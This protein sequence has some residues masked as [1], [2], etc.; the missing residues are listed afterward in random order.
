MPQEGEFQVVSK[1]K[2]TVLSIV[3]MLFIPLASAKAIKEV[4]CSTG[5]EDIISDSIYW[6]GSIETVLSSKMQENLPFFDSAS[7][8]EKLAGKKLIDLQEGCGRIPNR[9]GILR[10][11]S[12]L[13][14]RYRTN[15]E[16]I[17][18]EIYSYHFSKLLDIQINVIPPTLSIVNSSLPFWRYVTRQMQ[19]SEWQNGHLSIITPYLKRTSPVEIPEGLVNTDNKFL[20]Y[21]NISLIRCSSQKTHLDL[22]Q[23]SDMI[24]FDYLTGNFDRVVNNMFNLQWYARSLEEPIHNLLQSPNNMWIL[25]DNEDGLFHSFRLLEKYDKFLITLLKRICMF[26]KKTVENLEY[27]FEMSETKLSQRLLASV[28]QGEPLAVKHLPEIPL[29]NVKI[30]KKR[31]KDVID[32]ITS[33]INLFGSKTKK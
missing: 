29:A 6:S 25:I 4:I 1:V 8:K 9:L 18:G 11:G 2:S 14:F 16:Q 32:Q 27:L 13:C 20:L 22:I 12:Q 21:P 33:C 3:F 26:Q 17:L 24:I 31:I 7:F 19:S 28:V 30:L 10:D 5:Q 15:Q 23:W